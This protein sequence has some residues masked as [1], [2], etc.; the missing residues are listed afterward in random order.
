MSETRYRLGRFVLLVHESGALRFATH[1]A[2]GM[3]RSG[4]CNIIGRILV[5][6]PWPREEHGNLIDEFHDQRELLPLP[7]TRAVRPVNGDRTGAPR[8]RK[9]GLPRRSSDCWSG[10]SS[11]GMRHR[12]CCT[13]NIPR[14]YRGRH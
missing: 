2:L 7:G 3:E 4:I 12:N 5:I 11:L 10:W 9:T 8:Q 1:A 13:T 14:E 6:G